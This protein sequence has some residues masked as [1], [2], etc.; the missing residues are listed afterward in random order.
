M[1]FSY[2]GRTISALLASL[3]LGLGMT[4]CGGYTIGYMYILSGLGATGTQSNVITGYKIDNLTGNLTPIV[5]SPFPS[6]GTN[7]VNAVVLTGGR[8]LYVLNAGGNGSAGNVTQYSIGGDGVLTFQQSYTSQGSNPVWISADSS[9]RYIYVLDQLAPDKSGNGDVTV[10]SVDGVTGR[11]GLVVNQQVKNAAGTQLTYFPVGQHPIVMKAISSY[12]YVIDQTP[13]KNP[14]TGAAQSPIQNVFAYQISGSNGQLLLTQ[15]A[16]QQFPLGDNLTAINS[17]AGGSYV[18]IADAANN[19]IIPFTV[20]S[21]GV[22]QQLV[23]GP[24]RNAPSAANPVWIMV[25]SQGKFVYVLNQNN[26]N[27]NQPNSSITAFTIDSTNGILTQLGDSP[28][29]TGSGPVCMV[30]DPTN[31]YVYTSNHNDS[32][33]TGFILNVITGQ[34]APLNRRTVFP[35]SGNPTCLVT[36][37]YTSA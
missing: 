18:Y 26:T 10:F 34:L 29:P 16:P 5:S 6:G 36:S 1:K 21:G 31:Q 17:S 30:E 35:T 19:Q 23:G 9:G 14:V 22:L 12:L 7:P 24:V 3:A 2:L 37:Q 33:V 32:T 25:D 11:L 4:A 15:N 27:I 13:P 20:G 28:Y 8:F